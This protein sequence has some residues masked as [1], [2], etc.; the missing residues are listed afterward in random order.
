MRALSCATPVD[1]LDPS[2][3]PTASSPVDGVMLPAAGLLHAEHAPLIL[4]EKAALGHRL[5]DLLGQDDV[6]AVERGEGYGE[7]CV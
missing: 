1:I 4:L 3:L 6:T 2:R 7:G 5:G